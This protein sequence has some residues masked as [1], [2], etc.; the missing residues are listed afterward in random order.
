MPVGHKDHRGVPVS[1]TV[2]PR[3]CHQALDL[4]FR[5]VLAAPQVSVGRPRG[6]DCSI[7]DGWR[8][9]LEMRFRHD[10]RP[11]CRTTV[12]IMIVLETV[13]QQNL[14]VVLS[15]FDLPAR[16][17]G[18]YL[19]C[20][21][22]EHRAANL[23]AIVDDPRSQGITTQ[24]NERGIVTPRRGTWHPTSAARLLSRLQA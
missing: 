8:D 16:H 17:R 1:P 20:R 6:C 19:R 2:L 11:P 7:Y 22:T 12:G 15:H 24:L 10:F 9:Q 5:Q 21:M 14:I 23:R 13:G 18:V 3:R 4:G